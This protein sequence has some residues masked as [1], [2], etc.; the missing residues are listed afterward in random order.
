MP[1]LFRLRRGCMMQDPAIY[2]Q[3]R[4]GGGSHTDPQPLLLSPCSC[5]YAQHSRTEQGWH[6]RTLLR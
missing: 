5:G 2:G 1:I 6:L 3:Q 4:Q